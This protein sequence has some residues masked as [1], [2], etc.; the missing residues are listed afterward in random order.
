VGNIVQNYFDA[1]LDVTTFKAFTA[2]RLSGA[3][4]SAEIDHPSGKVEQ[5]FAH[6]LPLW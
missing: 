3:T 2:F 6:N 5:S 4:D 1:D